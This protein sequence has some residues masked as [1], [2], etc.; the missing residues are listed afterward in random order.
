MWPLE[1]ALEGAFDEHGN[2]VVRRF[3]W[4]VPGEMQVAWTV[5]GGVARYSLPLDGETWDGAG[6]F[7]GRS[8]TGSVSCALTH[9]ASS[10]LGASNPDR[11][12]VEEPEVDSGRKTIRATVTDATGATAQASASVY[13][14]LSLRG[15]GSVLEGG[16]T[17]R[18]EGSLMTVPAGIDMEIDG[19]TTGD[20]GTGGF[21]LRVAGREAWLFMEGVFDSSL[22]AAER[23]I[24]SVGPS[25]A[26]AGNVKLDL[27][28]KLDG[29][30]QSIG[31]SPS[32]TERSP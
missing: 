23:T 16:K 22:R 25:G 4:Y 5:S 10:W 9:G 11:Y 32:V 30:V 27:N 13:A 24:R 17:Y 19:Y 14:V 2:R 20:G 29:L 1:E 21:W 31:R 15:S 28:A 8:G 26:V 6:A 18:V 7:V 12:F 3:G